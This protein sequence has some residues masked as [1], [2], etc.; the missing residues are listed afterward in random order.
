MMERVSG[1][2]PKYM[3]DGASEELY[4]LF[5]PDGSVILEKVQTERMDR[6]TR[7]MRLPVGCTVVHALAHW[8][9]CGV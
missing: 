8:G 4:P 9:W 3:V 6:I 5:R 2:F 7:L 1:E